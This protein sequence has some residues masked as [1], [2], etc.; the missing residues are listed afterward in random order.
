MPSKIMLCPTCNA[1]YPPAM[2]ELLK[3]Y[4]KCLLCDTS[5]VLF[6]SKQVSADA[7]ILLESL[8]TFPHHKIDLED[9]DVQLPFIQHYASKMH[10]TPTET[11]NLEFMVKLELIRSQVLTSVASVRVGNITS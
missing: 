3:Q 11:K 4:C 2:H 6:L 1:N 10:L 9:Y 8:P 5:I 7:A